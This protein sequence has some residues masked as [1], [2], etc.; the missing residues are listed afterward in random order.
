MGAVGLQ[1]ATAL[2]RPIMPS[3][4]RHAKVGGGQTATIAGY[5]ELPFEVAGMKTR[6]PRRELR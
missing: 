4:G 5:V 1:L 3:Y 2:G 6:L